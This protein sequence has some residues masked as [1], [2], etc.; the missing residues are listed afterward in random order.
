[1]AEPKVLDV[2]RDVI[3]VGSRVQLT[4]GRTRTVRHIEQ[5]VN[6]LVRLALASSPYGH[7]AHWAEETTCGNFR[8]SGLRVLLDDNEK[9]A[10]RDAG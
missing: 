8:A 4:D 1:M 9:E 6:G 3:A 5:P 7:D 2:N 10:A